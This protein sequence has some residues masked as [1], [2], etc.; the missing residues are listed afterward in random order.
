VWGWVVLVWMA[1]RSNGGCEGGG[2]G[3]ETGKGLR[4]VMPRAFEKVGPGAISSSKEATSTKAR[5]E[6]SGTFKR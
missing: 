4:W 2:G 5:G 1:G 3:M 6:N